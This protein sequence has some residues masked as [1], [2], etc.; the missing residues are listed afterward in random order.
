[1]LNLTVQP[2]IIYHMLSETVKLK[3]TI[4]SI[5]TFPAQAAV[6]IIKLSGSRS[7]DIV[8]SVFKPKN[9]K[10]LKKVRNFSLHYGHIIAGNGHSGA[11]KIDSVII[12]EVL[13][14]VMRAPDSYTRE[15]VVEIHSHSGQYLLNT[16]LELCVSK[17]ARLAEP[18]EFTKR[19]FLNGR[20][21]LV[22]AEGVLDAINATTDDSLR[23]SMDQLSGRLS[24]KLEDILEDLRR[25]CIELEASFSFPED[26]S[27]DS[28]DSL[29]LC[30]KAAKDIKALL[31]YSDKARLF[32]DGVR[33]VICG[34]TNVGKSSLL[35]MLLEEERVIVTSV[36][37]T[38]RDVIEESINI[39][40]LPLRISDTAGI[41]RP[42]DLIE[43]KAMQK[44]YSMIDSAD[45]I[46]FVVDSSRP[47]NKDDRSVL[48]KIADKNVVVVY[49]KSDLSS[50]VDRSFVDAYGFRS[51]DISARDHRGLSELEKAVYSAAGAGS[52]P[53]GSDVYVS[54]RRHIGLLKSSLPLIDKTIEELSGADF[55]DQAL[56]LAK[57]AYADIAAILG[58]DAGRDVLDDVF[59]SFCIGK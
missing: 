57:Q 2:L 18:G 48:K 50:R 47:L 1:M 17:G 33:C 40:G 11:K 9:N 6:G 20:I 23:L 25:V 19:A 32:R 10:N 15:D 45:L 14:A 41:L 51:V 31:R 4:V 39:R 5:A 54:N 34:K 7:I 59:S 29:R 13:V 27:I 53:K 38:T 36:A 58:R 30:R 44:S 37:G 22:Q 16:I 43:E 46:L 26:V 35:N 49:N 8:S 28:A 56:F 42:R 52:L 12:D 55:S 3:D 24:Q 21:D